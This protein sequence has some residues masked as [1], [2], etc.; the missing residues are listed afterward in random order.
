MS[1]PLQSLL[2]SL[3]LNGFGV[4]FV[5]SFPP[6]SAGGAGA[7]RIDYRPVGQGRTYFSYRLNLL[8]PELF[9]FDPRN[10]LAWWPPHRG[11]LEC[12]FHQSKI[13]GSITAVM[14]FIQFSPLRRCRCLKG[15]LLAPARGQLL[16]AL[17]CAVHG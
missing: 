10:H 6:N 12:D 8:P 15:G 4:H 14:R 3:F 17:P 1:A 2:I 5:C 11:E 13:M 7:G 16:Q 9:G